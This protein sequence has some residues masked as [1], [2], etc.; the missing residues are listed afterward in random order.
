MKR[1]ARLPHVACGLLLSAAPLLGHAQAVIDDVEIFWRESDVPPAPALSTQRMV[2]IDMPIYSEVMVGVDVNSVSVSSKDGVVRYVTLIQG[3][4]GSVSAYYQGVHCNAFQGRTYA[5]YNF[6]QNPPVWE[7]I[8]ESW[9]DLKEKKSRYAR[10]IAQ[11]GA[12]ENSVAAP[13]TAQ[14]QRAY[15]RNSKWRG[16]QF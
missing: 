14:A 5:R 8:D 9:H 10:A 3:R 6:D 4:D 7:N 2:Q 1:L 11:S 13:N 15:A 16:K 12:C